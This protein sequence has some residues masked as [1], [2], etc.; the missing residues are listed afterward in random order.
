M[1][2]ADGKEDEEEE[3]SPMTTGAS[4]SHRVMGIDWPRMNWEAAALK[5]GSSAE[6]KQNHYLG[7]MKK[8]IML[9]PYN[10][11]N[12]MTSLYHLWSCG[13]RKQ[14]LLQ[15]RHYWSHGLLRDT[16]QQVSTPSRALSQWATY[17]APIK[18]IRIAP[19]AV[20]N[21]HYSDKRSIKFKVPELKLG[22]TRQSELWWKL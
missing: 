2:F 8:S 14:Q 11:N 10:L 15:M 6:K 7:V 1:T 18:V 22:Q 9:V 16:K 5:K 4:E 13:W 20:W 17:K 21:L 3:G 12:K 19:N